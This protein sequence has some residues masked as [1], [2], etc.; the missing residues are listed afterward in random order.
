MS[1]SR[2]SVCAALIVIA[3]AAGAAAQSP[4]PPSAPAPA[5]EKLLIVTSLFDDSASVFRMQGGS[6]ASA[7]K[8]IATG[9]RPTE[10]C[11][12]PDGKRAYVS[13][14]GEAT[15]TVLDLDAL[16]AAATVAVPG[17]KVPD[18][19]AVSGDSRKLYLADQAGNKVFVLST[20]TTKVLK[21]IDVGEEPRRIVVARDGTTYVSSEKA[22]VITLG[23]DDQLLSTRKVGR[24]PRAMGL[25]PDQKTLLVASVDDD[26]ISFVD[27]ATGEVQT[28]IGAVGNSPQRVAVTVDGQSAVVVSRNSNSLHVIN[29]AGGSRR[30]GHLVPVGRTPMGLEL[31]DSANIA[32]VLLSGESLVAVVD[33]RSGDTVRVLPTG[34]YPMG[35]AFRR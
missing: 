13:N 3:G 18:G 11:V 12:S 34:R 5:R 15:V 26:A 14:S 9:K 6:A 4:A 35:L 30:A 24:G 25:S 16:T 1:V 19:C 23:K 31:G 8:V 22:G 17:L 2:T 28:T 32:Y 29:L 33:L 10:V 27:P 20:E 7:V 21:T